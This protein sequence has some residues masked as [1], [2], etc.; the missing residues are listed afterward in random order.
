MRAL[1]TYYDVSVDRLVRTD[2][3]REEIS[4]R[5]LS[6]KSI[7]PKTTEIFLREVPDALIGTV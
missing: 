5:L 6:L 3:T 7:E 2:S 4:Q 1:I